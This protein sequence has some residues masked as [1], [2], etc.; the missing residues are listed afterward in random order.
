VSTAHRRAWA[1][2]PTATGQASMFG[3]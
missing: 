3:A 2:M 1:A